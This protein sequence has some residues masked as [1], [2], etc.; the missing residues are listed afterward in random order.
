MAH[1]SLSGAAVGEH[2][3]RT[4]YII[5]S[6][7]PADHYADRA[8]G[9][10]TQNILKALGI[11]ADLRLALDREYF[12]KAVTRATK[13][14]CDVLHISTHGNENGISVCNDRDDPLCE[15]PQGYLWK[16]FVSLFQG[17]FAPPDARVISACNGA[18]LGLAR[19][20]AKGKKRPNIIIGSTEELYPADYVA[21]W[22]LLYR[23]FKREGIDRDSAQRALGDICAV[24]HESFR[25]LRWDDDRQSYRRY[26]GAGTLF[27]VIE[28][29]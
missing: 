23:L 14:G 17:P 2:Q 29:E 27:D 3:L 7:Y 10:I 12:K 21:A 28:R 18:S 1:C 9:A 6:N 13:A 22:A 20:F 8:D 15:L 26:P 11:R 5:D 19:A 4:V 25:Y 24:V 16:E